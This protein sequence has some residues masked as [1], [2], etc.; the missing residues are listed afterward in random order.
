MEPVIT[1]PGVQA[2]ADGASFCIRDWRGSGP[3]VLHVHHDDDEAWHVL[4][5]TLRFTFG[6]R[7]LE[8]AAGATVFVPAG[9]A[10]TYVA[11]EGSRYLLI[12]TPRLRDLIAELQTNSDLSAHPEIYRRH[13]SE[14]V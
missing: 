2:F 5:G 8:A 6:D 10:H 1:E 12:L 14:I 9:V 3:A 7:V 11:L 13:R 4:E